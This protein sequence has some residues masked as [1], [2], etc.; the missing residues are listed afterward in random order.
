[1]IWFSLPIID[2]VEMLPKTRDGNHFAGKLIRLGTAPAFHYGKVRVAESCDDFINK[3]K[4]YFKELNETRIASQ[5]YHSWI[6]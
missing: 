3:M 2:L 6:I 1:L 4:I 5:I